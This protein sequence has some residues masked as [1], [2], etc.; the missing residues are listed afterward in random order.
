MPTNIT[1]YRIVTRPES[2]HRRF[3]RGVEDRILGSG[4]LDAQP[5]LQGHV[6]S[7]E[8]HGSAPYTRYTVN[9]TDGTFASG[10]VWGHDFDAY[11]R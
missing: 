2:T 6:V 3:V 1:G 10:L 9:Y 11:T 7:T 8:S 5:G 4:M